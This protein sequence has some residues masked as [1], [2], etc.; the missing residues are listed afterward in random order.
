MFG[1]IDRMYSSETACGLCY[2]PGFIDTA[3]HAQMWTPEGLRR[4]GVALA[5]GLHSY[6]GDA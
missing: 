1:V 2:E 5:E 4:V 3:A 6:V